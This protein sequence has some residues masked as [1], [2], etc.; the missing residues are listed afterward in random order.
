ML[1]VSALNIAGINGLM[2]FKTLA[3]EEKWR[4][5]S[6]QNFYAPQN[7]SQVNVTEQL[8]NIKGT[9]KNCNN[10]TVGLM[11]QLSAA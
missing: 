7:A 10:E 8:R 11:A 1:K 2:E 3:A 4:I 6:V 5:L 9:G